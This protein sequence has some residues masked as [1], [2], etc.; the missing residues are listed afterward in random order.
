M[1]AKAESPTYGCEPHGLRLA[2]SETNVDGPLDVIDALGHRGQGVRHRALRV[3]V[4]V[5]AERGLH[6][7]VLLHLADDLGHF[8][9]Q[10]A[11]IGVAEHEAVGARRL[12]GLESTEGVVAV[13]LEA[14]EEMLGVVD[15]LLEVLEEVGDGVTDHRDVLVEGRPERMRH[16]EVPGLAEDGD[17]GRARLDQRLDIAVLL[18]P[19]A[20]TARGAEGGDLRGLEDGVLD[21]LEEAQILGVRA[22]PAA[23]DVVDAESVQ[24]LRDADLV[25]HGEGHA[26]ALG[27]VPE[28]GVVYLD[29]P[30]HGTAIIPLPRPGCQVWAAAG[31]SVA[32]RTARARSLRPPCGFT[33]KGRLFGTS[34]LG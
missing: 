19:H 14:V 30:R 27:A 4:D 10:A 22:G 33:A 7:H 9:G 21:A 24:A 17:H 2:S 12:R 29:F 32:S 13:L 34:R 26:F 25:L 20:G 5:D 11:A 23:L 31:H 3:V 8:V 18:R 1:W 15:D 28:R 16:V 6:L